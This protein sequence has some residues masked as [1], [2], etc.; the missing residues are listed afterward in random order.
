MQGLSLKNVK[1]TIKDEDIEMLNRK[2]AEDLAKQQE[3]EEKEKNNN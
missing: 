1:I 2:L 3:Q